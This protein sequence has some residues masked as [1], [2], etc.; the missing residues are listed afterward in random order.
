MQVQEAVR[1]LIKVLYPWIHLRNDTW[2]QIV[3]NL[4][5]YKPKLYDHYVIRR[6]PERNRV[7]CKTDEETKEN[8]GAKSIGFVVRDAEGDPLYTRVKRIGEANNMETNMETKSL[9]LLE[10]VHYCQEEVLREA[11][12]DS[13]SLCVKIGG[14]RV[15][16]IVGL[17][18]KN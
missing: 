7:K 6:K 1:K 3:T 8:L 5:E 14:T 18:R 17:S 4:K 12:I 9:T 10:A 16:S 2:P 15:E 13:G 11:I